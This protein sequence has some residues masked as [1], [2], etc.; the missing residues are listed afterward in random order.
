MTTLSQ[1]AFNVARDPGG[2]TI[3]FEAFPPM[4][5][6]GQGK[7][8]D[9]AKN[10]EDFDPAFFSVTYGA[11]GGTQERTLN[12]LADISQ[13]TGHNLAGHLTCVGAT[14]EQTN[15]VAEQYRKMGVKHIVALRGDT[16]D[17]VDQYQPHP[18]GYKNAADLVAG[19]KE[20]GGF[21]ISVGA[22]PE[23]HPDSPSRNADL[24]NLKAK[25]D[26]GADRAITQFFFDNHVF[27]DFMDSVQ[28]HGI[29]GPI[30][31]GILLIHD[32]WKVKRFAKMCQTDVPDWLEARFAGLQ[33]DTAAQ[34]LVAVSVA[35]EQVLEMA[36]SG[37]RHFHFYT[38]NKSD[39]AVAVCRSLGLKPAR[40]MRSVA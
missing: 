1:N 16:P 10:L 24:D 28:D 5:E 27:Y 33:G 7:L 6:A 37:V 31:P 22:Y 2:F 26:A 25:F 14:K 30:V 32:F 39:L 40:N 15:A 19:L 34:Q 20:I 36:A 9:V 8:L 4:S 11:G 21:D 29:T 3:S 17:G 38:M 18:G 13:K 23:S 12:T 35:V